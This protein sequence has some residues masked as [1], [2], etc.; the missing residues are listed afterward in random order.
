MRLH[1]PLFLVR[2]EPF[3]KVL[4]FRPQLRA[5]VNYRLK[6]ALLVLAVIVHKLL[7]KLALLCILVKILESRHFSF[8]L[9]CLFKVSITAERRAIFF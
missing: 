8:L 4:A 2:S 3:H 1:K 7:P 6:R 9:T 5:L